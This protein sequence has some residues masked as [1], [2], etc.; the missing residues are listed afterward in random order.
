MERR[1]PSTSLFRRNIDRD[2]PTVGECAEDDLLKRFTDEG[3]LLLGQA[4]QLD[5]GRELYDYVMNSI[6]I[7]L[8]TTLGMSSLAVVSVAPTSSDDRRIL[9]L[10]MI[11]K[12]VTDWTREQLRGATK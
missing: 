10:K 11:E 12:A 6:S 1:G 3:D 7:G 2:S 9:V 4:L 8:H 5:S